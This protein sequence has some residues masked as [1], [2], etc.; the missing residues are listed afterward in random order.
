MCSCLDDPEI[1]GSLFGATNLMLSTDG[2]TATKGEFKTYTKV[3]ESGNET[4][5]HFC[6]DCGSTLY[7]VSNGYPGVVLMK[8][9]CM[10]DFN[11]EDG[12]PA[13]EMFTREYVHWVPMVEGLDHKRA[14]LDSENLACANGK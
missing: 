8:A 5:I 2:L 7:R 12:K 6:G 3:V 1:T 14:G 4:T 11:P 9:G 13:L 10:D